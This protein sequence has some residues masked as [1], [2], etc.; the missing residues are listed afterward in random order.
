MIDTMP[1]VPHVTA[2]AVLDSY[3]SEPTHRAIAVSPDTGQTWRGSAFRSA[4]EAEQLVLERCQL[5][6]RD[7]CILFAVDDDIRPPRAGTTW[8]QRLM[9]RV[10]DA[11]GQFDARRIPLL[12]DV[13]RHMPDVA[14]YAQ[15]TTPKAMAVHP[16]G[17]AFIVSAAESQEKADADALGAC[18]SAV[19]HGG[20]SGLCVLYASGD[21]VVLNEHRTA[22]AAESRRVGQTKP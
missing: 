11:G 15:A 13:R 16:T 22:I 14:E 4:E 8:Q 9:P 20:P 21:Q 5:R 19:D 18:E 6:Y 1:F 10:S 7:G 12:T 3:L 17:R 2:E